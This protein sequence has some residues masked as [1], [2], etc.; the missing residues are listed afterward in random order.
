MIRKKMD[1]PEDLEELRGALKAVRYQQRGFLI[2]TLAEGTTV[3]GDMPSPQI[4]L[5]YA[6]RGR[7][8]NHPQWG[9]QFAFA[10]YRGS[11]PTDL[12]AVRAYLMENCKWIGPEI[13]KRLVNTYGQETLAICKADPERVAR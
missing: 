13:S 1:T 8:E 9:K 2:G 10:E 3:K 5:E 11:Y 4:G 7:W 12:E 6:F